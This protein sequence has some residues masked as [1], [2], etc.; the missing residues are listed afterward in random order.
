MNFL[1]LVLK[2][3]LKFSPD[4]DYKDG[5]F[6]KTLPKEGLEFVLSERNA[7]V[8]F[9]LGLL[10]LPMEFDLISEEQGYVGNVFGAMTQAISK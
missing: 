7:T 9:N 3:S 10:L 4:A 1:L 5:Q 2:I 8:T 6:S